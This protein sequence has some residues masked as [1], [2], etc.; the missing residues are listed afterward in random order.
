MKVPVVPPPSLEEVE[1]PVRS[2]DEIDPD[3]FG[4]LKTL[5]HGAAD[6]EII[7]G[8]MSDE[9]VYSFTSPMLCR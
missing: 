8:L 7:R 5:W 9:Y 3:I 4:N 2:P 1:K 6:E